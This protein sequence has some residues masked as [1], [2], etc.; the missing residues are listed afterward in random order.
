MSGVHGPAVGLMMPLDLKVAG[1]WV[2]LWRR[3]DEPS[4]ARHADNRKLWIN[5]RDRFPHPYTLRDAEGWIGLVLAQEPPTHFA[6][7]VGDEAVGGIGFDLKQDVDRRT[8]EIGFWLGEPFWGKGITT[9]AV[10]AVTDYAFATF[11]LSR[12]FGHVFEW[13]AASMRVLEKCGYMREARLRRA[14]VKDGKTIDLFVYA[15]IR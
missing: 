1:A 5:L 3:G 6:I 2:R 12:V 9:A 15:T 7:A 13:N 8:A 4:L 10:R 14:V 11:D